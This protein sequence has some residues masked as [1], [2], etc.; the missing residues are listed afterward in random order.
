MIGKCEICGF[1]AGV[2]NLV[3]GKCKSCSNSTNKHEVGI[4]D[5]TGSV[6][7][8][9]IDLDIKRNY[10]DL[11]NGF[12]LVLIGVV[13]GSYAVMFMGGGGQ[14]GSGAA[15]L[16]ILPIIGFVIAIISIKF[17]FALLSKSKVFKD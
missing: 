13:F 6:E 4:S 15:L 11:F 9:A 17:G 16:V 8:E 5:N 7:V 10:W 3:N 1:E 2:I 12:I 14:H